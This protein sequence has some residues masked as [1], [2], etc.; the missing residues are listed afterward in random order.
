MMQKKIVHGTV[1][2][3]VALLLFAFQNCSGGDLPEAAQGVTPMSS[4]APLKL[5]VPQPAMGPS[6]TLI[7]SASGGTP[8]YRF[9][10]V[11]GPVTVNADTGVV[12][13]STTAGTIAA[14]VT[15]STDQTSDGSLAVDLSL[16]PVLAGS[17]ELVAAGTAA[18]AFVVPTYHT[19]T[20][21]V[22]GAGGGGGGAS[23]DGTNRDGKDGGASS[24]VGGGLNLS[25][26][27]GLHGTT[28]FVNA[29]GGT[30]GR[31]GTL[32]TMGNA[33]NTAGGNGVAPKIE[34]VNGVFVFTGAP[35]GPGANGG[36]GGTV[37]YAQP[38]FTGA[39]GEA[40][41]GGGGG[42]GYLDAAANN[43]L[44]GSGGGGAYLKS[45]FTSLSQVPVGTALTLVVGAGGAGTATGVQP[46]AGA[47]ANGKI[48]IVW[49]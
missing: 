13:S 4:I 6:S 32:P 27:G 14:R 33:T 39:G 11:S 44:S 10:I 5:V 15:D 28:C 12:T 19:L 3:G 41:G 45:T 37:S 30:S 29:Q 46:I 21:E 40:P 8:P 31:G 17:L 9:S 38:R 18:Q 26:S 1:V 35:G 22:W 16:A 43:C 36:A 20:I 24:V 48:K 34:N 49:N 7:L 2:L 25:A 42:S 47:G 23:G